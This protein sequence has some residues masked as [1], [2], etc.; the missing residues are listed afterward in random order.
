MQ[1][2]PTMDRDA[3]IALA[4]QRY[5]ASVDAKNIEATLACF[6]PTALF[7]VQ[8][9]F[10]THAGIDEI[11]RMFEDFFAAYAVIVHRGFTVTV[12]E[13]S[14]RIAASFEAVLTGHDGLIT[15]LDNTNFWRVRDG[16]FR[17][18]HV[19]MSGANVLV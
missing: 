5:F 18:V 17:E 14:G 6:D 1:Y 10:T 2:P 7:T 16:R 4:T 11:R 8:T 3:L 9:S 19:Y 12:D 15:R 13:A